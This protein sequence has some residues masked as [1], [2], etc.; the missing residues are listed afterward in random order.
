MP[1]SNKRVV[2]IGAG[3]NGL[4]AAYYLA[5]AGFS[6]LVLERRDTIGGAVVTGEIHPGFQCPVLAHALGPLVPDLADGLRLGRH[7]FST[8]TPDLNVLALSREGPP[9]S[10]YRDVSRTV[11][12][13]AS[14]S[15]HDSKSYA[16]FHASFAAIGK[17]LAPLMS[18]TPPSID[19][20]S[21]MEL[22]NLGKVGLKFRDL[23][24]KD[25]FRLLRWGPMAV[26]DLAAEWFE[27]E[28]LRAVVA[29]PGIIGTFAGPWSAGTSA[30]ALFIA[31]GGGGPGN[32]RNFCRS[33]VG[34]NQRTRTVSGRDWR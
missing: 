30:P 5:K 26:A 19:E 34:W 8:I 11:R 12:E 16:E 7:G 6:P 4:V 29:A 31:G 28:L 3:H 24:K 9:I 10:I 23:S 13:L 2:I 18:M 32:Y 15:A 17:V 22:W 33:M 20:P 14:I 25:A 1:A 21:R 27:T